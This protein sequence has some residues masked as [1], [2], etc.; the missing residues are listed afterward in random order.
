MIE[1]M[2]KFLEISV[3]SGAIILEVIGVYMMFLSAMRAFIC[4]VQTREFGKYLS[5]G[6]PHALE[7]LMCSEVLKTATANSTKDYVQL[8]VIIALR[9]ALA[10]EVHWE[11]KNHAKEHHQTEAE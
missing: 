8:A 11:N 10:L 3:E 4:W 9:F 1:M 2:E 7:F 6:I 5:K